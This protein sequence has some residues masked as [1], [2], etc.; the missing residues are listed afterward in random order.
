[1]ALCPPTQMPISGAKPPRNSGV[2]HADIRTDLAHCACDG[3][4]LPGGLDRRTCRPRIRASW[5]GKPAESALSALAQ[6][7]VVIGGTS[8]G[9]A[10]ECFNAIGEGDSEDD[11]IAAFMAATAPVKPG[12]GLL[13]GA[14]LGKGW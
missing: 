11:A 7:G 6:R 3:H 10:G 1:M 14:A 2:H 13:R 5:Q 9:A 12:A 8:A 4:A